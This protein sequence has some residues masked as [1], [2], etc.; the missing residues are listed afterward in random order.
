M[1]PEWVTST[2]S[3]QWCNSTQPQW[4]SLWTHSIRRAGWRWPLAQWAV[5]RTGSQRASEATAVCSP[6]METV[7]PGRP[8]QALAPPVLGQDRGTAGAGLAQLQESAHI[9]LT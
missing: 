8:V 4:D 7:A 5:G 2:F 9:L 1:Y 6:G 3:P